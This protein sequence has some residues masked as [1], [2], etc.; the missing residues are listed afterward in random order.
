MVGSRCHCGRWSVV[1]V[2]EV[3]GLWSV[4]GW[5]AVVLYYVLPRNAK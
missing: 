4:A 3:G 1:G 2:T 5:W